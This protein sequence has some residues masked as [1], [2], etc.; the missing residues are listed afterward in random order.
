LNRCQTQSLPFSTNPSGWCILTSTTSVFMLH[1]P[2]HSVALVSIPFVL[3][4][5][6]YRLSVGPS[7][8]LLAH[9]YA[10]H[11]I[12]SLVYSGVCVVFRVSPAWLLVA[13]AC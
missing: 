10:L 5:V 13:L 6:S 12:L 9:F 3:F 7:E 4:V 11:Y 1:I 8:R 2:S